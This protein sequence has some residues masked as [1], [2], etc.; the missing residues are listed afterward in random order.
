[1]ELIWKFIVPV[2]TVTNQSSLHDHY[3]TQDVVPH[4]QLHGIV[5][6]FRAAGPSHLDQPTKSLELL[7]LWPW[8]MHEKWIKN[9]WKM[10]Q[11]NGWEMDQIDGY[12]KW[13]KNG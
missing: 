5:Q 3:T 9:G 4:Q 8:K 10:D 2:I 6:L 11:K 7:W 12:G 13:M 1:M